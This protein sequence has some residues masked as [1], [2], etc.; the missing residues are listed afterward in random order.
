MAQGI[1]GS[2]WDMLLAGGAV[3]K[4]LRMSHSPNSEAGV[5]STIVKG[6]V[7]SGVINAVINGGIQW[8]LLAKHAPLPLT[9]DG[10]S[11][12]EHTVF[13]A[14][15]PL[16][17]SLAMILTAVAYS[18]IKGEKPK[19]FPVFLGMTVK[20]GFFA[21]GIVITFA[22]LWQR[23]FGTILVPLWGAVVILG[24]VAGVVSAIVNCMTL[25][26]AHRRTANA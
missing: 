9:V 12:D 8:W 17:V 13:G 2:E 25:M 24:L 6:A 15:V 4:S 3:L 22:V 26:E 5:R 10:I 7:L 18:T 19:F 21:L 1:S 16:A 11:N 23:L 14:A 20:H